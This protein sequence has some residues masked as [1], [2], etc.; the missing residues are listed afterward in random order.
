MGAFHASKRLSWLRVTSSG[1]LAVAFLGWVSCCSAQDST[2]RMEQIVQDYVDQKQF[3]GSV[4]VAQ[5]G[6][7]LFEKGYGYANLEWDIPNSPT[8]KFPIASMTKQFTAACILLLEERGKLNVNDP[9]KKYMPDAPPA[10]DKV[11]I[12]NLLTHTSGIP[13]SFH[14][15]GFREPK[16]PEQLVGYFRD[17]PLQFEPGTAAKY[18]NAGY[19]LLGYLIEKISGQSY[20]DFVQENIFKPLGMNDSGYDPNSALLPRRASGYL[21]TPSGAVNAFYLDMSLPYSAGGLYSTVEDL[22]K[23]ERALFDAKL[24][25]AAS[26]KKMITPFMYDYYACGLVVSKIGGRTVIEHAGDGIPGF[27]SDMVFYPDDKLTVIVLNNFAG[28]TA[29]IASKLAAAAHGEKVILPS[30]RKEFAV[31]PATLAKYAGTY[32]GVFPG[33]SLII[34][35]EGDHLMAQLTTG[36]DGAKI[37]LRAVA[38]RVFFQNNPEAEFTFMENDKGEIESVLYGPGGHEMKGLKN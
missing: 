9:I 27:T 29:G 17:A 14:G 2:P 30:E 18:S 5:G 11:T 6:K 32:S 38:D 10:W 34:T 7:I 28:E 33:Y 15:L 24:L 31:S 36:Q 12:Y 19:F 25:S 21:L 26:L 23:W 20:Q 1:V 4:A 37:A 13:N 16:T 22:L 3:M 35:V 8:T